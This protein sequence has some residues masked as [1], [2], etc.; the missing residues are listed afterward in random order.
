MDTQY[1]E[2]MLD[3]EK[4][5]QHVSLYASYFDKNHCE[6]ALQRI[7]PVSKSQVTVTRKE[8]EDAIQIK[9]LKLNITFKLKYFHVPLFELL[10]KN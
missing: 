10:L 2:L 9:V 4:C 8:M 7:L 6:S 5:F 3:D 1:S